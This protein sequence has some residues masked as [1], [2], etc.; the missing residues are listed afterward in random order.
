MIKEKKKKKKKKFMD[1]V[2]GKKY[3]CFLT[4][5]GTNGRYK[6][7]GQVTDTLTSEMDSC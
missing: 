3:T 5:L 1:F 6:A 2:F 7:S 4:D